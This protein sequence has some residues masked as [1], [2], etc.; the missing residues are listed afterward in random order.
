MPNSRRVL[1]PLTAA[2]ILAYFFFFTWNSRHMYFDTDDMYALY[3]AWSKPLGQVVRENLYLWKGEF[4]PLGAFFYRGI[5]A[6]A[7]FD[8]FPFRIAEMSVCVANIAVCFWF[9][10]LV[11]ASERTAALATLLFAF[12]ARMLEVWF[13]TTVI[14]D[15]LCFTFIFLAAGLYIGARRQGGDLSAGRIAAILVIFV[16]ALNS[17]EFAVC[18]PVFLMAW[19]L[20]FNR[21]RWRS[22]LK[23]RAAALIAGLGILIVIYAVGKLH[24]AAAMSN[25]PAYTPEYSYARFSETWGEYL[26]DLFVLQARPAGWVSLTILGGMLALAAAMRS[27]ILAF[28]WVILFFGLLPVSFAPARGGYEIYA[29]SWLGWVLYPAA[30]LV[31]LQDFVTRHIP[32]CRTALACAVFVLVGWRVGKVNLHDLRHE[33]RPWLYQPPAEVRA[34][35]LQ[36][37]KM[38]PTMP[39]QARVLFL[40]DGFTTGEWTPLFIVRLIYNNPT[41][42]VDRVKLKTDRPAGWEQYTSGDRVHYDYVFTYAQGHYQQV[43]PT[44]IGARQQP[45]AHSH[46]AKAS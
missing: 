28:A 7:G 3:F 30:L 42:V 17:K 32:Q 18:L 37:L 22:F 29:S 15:V 40:E 39:A 43:Q 2:I 35:A 12:Q 24:G 21:A 41:M 14:F 26:K 31:A 20:L 38:H 34:M 46:G 1:Y 36:L 27:R 10:R 19:E 4:R 11:S 6:L 33:D 8:P 5:F 45:L 44:I 9:T 23:S 25:N 13:R 16:C